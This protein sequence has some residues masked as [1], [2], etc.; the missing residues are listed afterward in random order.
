[1]RRPTVTGFDNGKKITF[2]SSGNNVSISLSARAG[3][4]TLANMYRPVSEISLGSCST[5][6][7][8]GKILA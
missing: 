8:D 1:M 7:S 5:K 4:D 6:T 3:I 2:L